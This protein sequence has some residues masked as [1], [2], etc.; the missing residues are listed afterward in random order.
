MIT[1]LPTEWVPALAGQTSLDASTAR[2]VLRRAKLAYTTRGVG[3]DAVGGILAGE[4]L[5]PEPGDV[6]LATVTAI[7]QHKRIE[8]HDGRR[9]TLFPGDEVVVCFGDRYAPDQFEA[10]VPPRL[11]PCDLVAAGGVASQMCARHSSMGEP[12]AIAPVGLLAYKDGRRINLR[13]WALPRA[14]PQP[15]R[16]A[17]IAVLGTSMNAG[18]TTSAAHLIYGLASS[19]RR[20]AAAKVTGTGAG[21]DV[22]LMQD[23]GASPVLDFTHAGHAS[24]AGLTPEA[25]EDVLLRLTADLAASGAE[26]IVLEIADGLFQAETAALVASPRFAQ[27]VD[28][29]LFAGSDALG[30]ALGTRRLADLGLPVAGVTGLV[31]ASPLATREAATATGLPV[32]DIDALRDPATAGAL[33]MPPLVAA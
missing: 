9:A 10:H 17:T 33:L 11:Q 29:V 12:T 32:L 28:G 31:T 4:D 13:D 8:L 2:G 16:P 1:E 21:G 25:V 24:T 7:G 20:V 6:V 22:W 18:K 5:R 23:A 30:V 27:A 14:E 15:G 3:L 19:G 26:A